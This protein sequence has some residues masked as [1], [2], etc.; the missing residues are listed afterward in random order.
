[1]KTD[2]INIDDFEQMRAQLDIMKKKLHRQEI[3]NS[4]LMSEAM[5]RKISWIRKF[6]WVEIAL[7][8]FIAI[9]YAVLIAAFHISPL[10][11]AVIM[12]LTIGDVYADYRINKMT[13]ADW[14]ASNLV[15]TGRKLVK[16]KR[17]RM[18]HFAVAGV[19]ALIVFGWLSYEMICGGYRPMDDSL[20]VGC[21]I[22]M[23]VG[24]VVG[25]IV[26][27]VIYRKM[28]RTNDDIIRQIDDLMRET[29][30]NDS[31]Q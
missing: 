12:V 10:L 29:D 23:G 30:M 26:A 5:S 28:Q 24:A 1:M 22:G 18:I 8:P 7:L 13:S 27:Y 17:V 11:Y 2:N 3:V 14:L 25:L 9:V 20:L 19:L 21:G 16:M 31:E 6:I 4:R 15:E